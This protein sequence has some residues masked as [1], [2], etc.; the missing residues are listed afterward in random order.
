MTSR[1]SRRNEQLRAYDM[2]PH[3]MS[4]PVTWRPYLRQA[5]I[6]QAQP[7]SAARMQSPRPS[8]SSSEAKTEGG[9]ERHSP[10]SLARRVSNPCQGSQHVQSVKV[11]LPAMSRQ[12]MPMKHAV[13]LSRTD[14]VNTS[15]KHRQQGQTLLCRNPL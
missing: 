7:E 13:E 14:D 4:A 15:I 1:K 5:R 3:L 6:P 9:S 2:S 8:P 12:V 11:R 10:P